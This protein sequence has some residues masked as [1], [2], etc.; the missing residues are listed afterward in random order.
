MLSSNTF[1]ETRIQRL[2][3]VSIFVEQKLGVHVPRMLK[4]S[5]IHTLAEILN[6]FFVKKR[7]Q[8][9][10]LIYDL[11]LTNQLNFYLNRLC[12]HC[13]HDL[14]IYIRKMLTKIEMV[15]FQKWDFFRFFFILLL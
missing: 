3:D 8:I 11:G 2:L 15:N 6:I 5:R 4:M 1:L 9:G 13:L 10:D 12:D 14:H 7:R